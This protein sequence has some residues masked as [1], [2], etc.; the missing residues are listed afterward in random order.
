MPPDGSSRNSRLESYFFVDLR[1]EVKSGMLI[2]DVLRLRV[3][4][5]D[6]G[7]HGHLLAGPIAVLR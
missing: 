7:S 5:N 4:M 2:G 3:S 6:S 1:V